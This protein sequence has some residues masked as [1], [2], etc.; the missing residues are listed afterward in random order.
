[1]MI[2]RLVTIA[3]CVIVHVVIIVGL[4]CTLVNILTYHGCV[5]NKIECGII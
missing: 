4:Y 3:I 1:M 2:E 5:Q